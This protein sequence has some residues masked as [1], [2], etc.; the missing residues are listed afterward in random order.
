MA[1]YRMVFVGLSP[2][3]T[4]NPAAMQTT[5]R[6]GKG[7]Q[8]P[9]AEQEAEAGCYRTADGL[10]AAPGIAFRNS[11]LE[12]APQ[13]RAGR[14]YMSAVLAHITV[15]EDLVPLYRRDG[16]P[17]GSYEIDMRRAIVQGQGIIRARPKFVDWAGFF[18]VDYDEA[19][20]T[21][22]TRLR[23]IAND[24]GGRI[25][26]GDYRPKRR[27]WF[28]RFAIVEAF[29]IAAPVREIPQAK[30]LVAIARKAA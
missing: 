5:G 6:G 1:L 4:H 13:W 21:D 7:R 25:G 11:I 9:T 28:G 23:D 20:V 29:G 17:V 24:A 14:L 18:T 12:A 16:S 30:E 27:G 22:L 3:L 19:L 10:F 15:V 2:L 26:V 8:I